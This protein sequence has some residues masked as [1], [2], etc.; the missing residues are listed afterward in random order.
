M[1]D[2][3][4][5]VDPDYGVSRMRGH[6]RGIHIV[7]MGQIMGVSR[8]WGIQIVGDADFGGIQIVRVS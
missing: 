8:L 1:G 4:C 3:D 5:G 6:H 2:P 7:G